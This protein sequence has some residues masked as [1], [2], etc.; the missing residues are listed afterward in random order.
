MTQKKADLTTFVNA[1]FK[2]KANWKLLTAEDKEANFFIFNR[3]MSKAYPKQAQSFNKR[4]LDKA[5]CADIWFKFLQRERYTPSWFWKYRQ[6]K[7][8]ENV[9]KY[10]KFLADNEISQKDLLYLQSY[11]PDILETEF[12]RYEQ[13]QELINS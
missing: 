4:Y 8:D 1:M 13:I 5:I 11:Y 3:F 7:K 2:D 9:K 6:G 10:E 12:K